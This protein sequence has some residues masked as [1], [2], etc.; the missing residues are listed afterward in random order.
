MKNFDFRPMLVPIY[1]VIS[2]F[3]ICITLLTM[4]TKDVSFAYAFIGLLYMCLGIFISYTKF[5]QE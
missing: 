1:I 4:Y 3:F 2:I 5:N